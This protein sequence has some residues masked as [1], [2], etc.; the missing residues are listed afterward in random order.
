MSSVDQVTEQVLIE[1]TDVSICDA[2]WRP[3]SR[4]VAINQSTHE[5]PERPV[6]WQIHATGARQLSLPAELD[7]EQLLH[8]AD[9]VEPL[10]WYT[11]QVRVT[12]WKSDQTLAIE[13]FG[14]AWRLNGAERTDRSLA[15]RF[16]LKVADDGSVSVV[17]RCEAKHYASDRG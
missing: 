17:H 8:K 1:R 2:V 16:V 7:P 9:S 14:G 13:T 10:Q 12:H 6:L 11:N 3:D 5:K 15:V 4:A